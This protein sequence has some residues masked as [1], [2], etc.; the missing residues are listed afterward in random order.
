MTMHNKNHRKFQECKTTK[1]M[2]KTM[3]K[4]FKS[5]QKKIIWTTNMVREV[6]DMTAK[7]RDYLHLFTM[8]SASWWISKVRTAIHQNGSYDAKQNF[9]LWAA[10]NHQGKNDHFN[11]EMQANTT[12]TDECNTVLETPQMSMKQGL[13][14]FGQVGVEAVK[15]KML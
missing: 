2:V 12:S 5:I 3:T 4:V 14:L 10:T 1:Q 6:A 9:E 15:R 8:K 13:K 11:S 7:T